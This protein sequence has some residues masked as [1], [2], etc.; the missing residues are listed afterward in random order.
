MI[1]GMHCRRLR[2]TKYNHLSISQGRLIIGIFRSGWRHKTE[3]LCTRPRPEMGI[4][5]M[6]WVWRRRWC[7]FLERW[8]LT[9]AVIIWS[10]HWRYFWA[11][12]CWLEWGKHGGGH[13]NKKNFKP[14][15]PALNY[16]SSGSFRRARTR[17]FLKEKALKGTFMMAGLWTL[18]SAQ[19]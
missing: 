18:K 12:D 11:R 13:F 17:E 9:L 5:V 2:S 19:L 15:A 1:F 8:L 4:K 10:G 3:R 6:S 14:R 7:R 16:K